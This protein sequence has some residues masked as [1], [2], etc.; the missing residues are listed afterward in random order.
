MGDVLQVRRPRALRRAGGEPLWHQL[1]APDNAGGH[2]TTIISPTSCLWCY[3]GTTALQSTLPERITPIT[4]NTNAKLITPQHKEVPGDIVDIVGG[5]RNWLRRIAAK[6]PAW[7]SY[8]LAT[9]YP[10]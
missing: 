6:I 1:P 9:R 8:R 4:S 2:A 5:L 3:E 10:T 7:V